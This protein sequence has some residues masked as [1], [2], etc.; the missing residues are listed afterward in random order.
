MPELGKLLGF[1]QERL[2]TLRNYEAYL[3]GLQI[4]PNSLCGKQVCDW[5]GGLADFV[6][7]ANEQGASCRSIDI[8]YGDLSLKELFTGLY[9]VQVHRFGVVK[10]ADFQKQLVMSRIESMLGKCKI[11]GAKVQMAIQLGDKGLTSAIVDQYPLIHTDA[12]RAP[13]RNGVFDLIVSNN[14]LLWSDVED[15]A[16]FIEAIRVLKDIG[17]ELR[18]FPPAMTVDNE[19]V[20]MSSMPIPKKRTGDVDKARHYQT[21]TQRH[22][23]LKRLQEELGLNYYLVSHKFADVPLNFLIVRKDHFVPTS[24]LPGESKVVVRQ[25]DFNREVSNSTNELAVYSQIVNIVR[26]S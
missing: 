14:F 3:I 21:N 8:C 18:V 10:S 25:V 20:V 17:G 9:P 13:M 19:V 6:W 12:E 2:V 15:N 26:R 5:G 22:R 16:Q 23:Q 1:S 24:F 7:F 4:N 11:H